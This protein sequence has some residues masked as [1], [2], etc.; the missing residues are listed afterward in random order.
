MLTFTSKS[1]ILHTVLSGAGATSGFIL[2]LSSLV[3]SLVALRL[4]K[5]QAKAYLFP[6]PAVYADAATHAIV[7]RNFGNGAML[8]IR[9]KA[10]LIAAT[11]TVEEIVR[12]VANLAHNE[13]SLI[14]GQDL[15]YMNPLSAL[16]CKLT[17]E[18]IVGGKSETT[19][20]LDSLHLQALDE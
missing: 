6:A 16:R 13:T 1:E 15:L 2:A 11:Q 9:I 18:N 7:L 14:I 12:Y 5:E 20:Y 10:E 4:T 3:V 19:F 8:N 17:Y